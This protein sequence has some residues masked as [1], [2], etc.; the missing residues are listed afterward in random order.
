MRRGRIIRGDHRQ[1]SKNMH[2]FERLSVQLQLLSQL[3]LLVRIIWHRDGR[4]VSL[5]SA[6][7][8]VLVHFLRVLSGLVLFGFPI[9]TELM[10]KVVGMGLSLGILFTLVNSAVAVSPAKADAFPYEYIILL[11]GLLGIFQGWV[12]SGAFSLFKVR[13]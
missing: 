7:L 13:A 11:G 2:E 12:E 3:L 4:G 10:G 8:L 5:K 9:M 1:R 6:M